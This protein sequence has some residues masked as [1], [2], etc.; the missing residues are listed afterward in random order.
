MTMFVERGKIVG[1]RAV[2][3]YLKKRFLMTSREVAD[4]RQMIVDCAAENGLAVDKI[5]V[6]ELDMASDQLSECLFTLADVDEPVMIIPDLAHFAGNGNPLEIRRA[7]EL[8]GIKILCA[9]SR[10]PSIDIDPLKE[11]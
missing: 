7:F 3:G 1:T 5:F 8:A 6:A 4:L 2:C 10:P 9:R 11:V